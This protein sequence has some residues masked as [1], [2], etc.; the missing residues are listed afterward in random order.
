M[1]TIRDDAPASSPRSPRLFIAVRFPGR[2]ISEL[3][4]LSGRLKKGIEF[5]PC[6]PSWT[7]PAMMHLTLRFLGPTPPEDVDRL[8][9][10]IREVLEGCEPWRLKLSK[11]G[12]FPDWKAPRVLW[13]GAREKS[14]QM[15]SAQERIEDLALD[16]GFDP[17]KGRFKPHV[18]LARFKSVKGISAA[19]KV[20]ESHEQ[21]AIGPFEAN[22]VV[23]YESVRREAGLSYEPIERFRLKAPEN[24]G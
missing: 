2:A 24:K 4:E 21:F 7:A 18:T 17:P 8:R 20:V 3:E 1:D 19:R 23:L 10:G 14:G 11:F 15:H 13:L 16:L 9:S 5:T 22:E 12:A 6:R